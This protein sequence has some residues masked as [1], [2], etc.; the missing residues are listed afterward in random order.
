VAFNSPNAWYFNTVPQVVVTPKHE[1]III[2]T[3]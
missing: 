2:S 3:L 1:I